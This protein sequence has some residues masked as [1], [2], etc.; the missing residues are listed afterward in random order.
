MFLPSESSN[1]ALGVFF[2]RNNNQTVLVGTQGV[3]CIIQTANPRYS[4]Q[5]LRE[6]VFSLTIPAENMTE[7]EQK[8]TWR[9][10][11]LFNASY[12]SP[13]VILTIAGKLKF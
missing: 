8:S 12:K 4:Y 7:F 6:N 5:C 13:D 3:Q 2:F 10:E 11:Y 9:C 1:K